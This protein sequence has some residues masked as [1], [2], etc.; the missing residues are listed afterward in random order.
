MSKSDIIAKNTLFLYIRMGLVLIVSLYTV[1]VLLVALGIVEYGV[2]SAVGGVINTLSF[3]SAVLTNASQ[4]FFSIEIGKDNQNQLKEIFNS[5]FILYVLAG[6]ILL[7][8]FETIGLWFLHNKMTIPEESKIAA[9]WVFQCV[10]ISFIV[11]FMSSPFQSLIIA[12]ERMNI[13]AVVGLIDVFLKLSITVIILYIKDYRLIIYSLLL[14]LETL[15]CQIIYILYCSRHYNIKDIHLSLNKTIIYPIINYTKWSIVGAIAFISNTQG[16]NVI[17]NVFFGPVINTAYA[18]GNQVKNAINLFGSNFF[19]AV[20]PAMIKEYTADNIKY[21]RQLFY[22]SSKMIF[23]LLYIFSLPLLLETLTI[24]NLWLTDINTDMIVF[25]RLMLIASIILS[26]S[27][28]ITTTIQASGDVKKYHLY[29]DGFILVTLPLIYTAFILG[30]PAQYAIIISIIVL[31]FAHL[32]RL[33]L[34][35]QIIE[36]RIWDYFIKIILPIGLTIFISFSICYLLSN[37]IPF[38]TLTSILKCL[39][40]AIIALL[41][42]VFVMLSTNEKKRLFDIIKSILR[43]KN[44][45]LKEYS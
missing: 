14:L 34:V 17:L 18:I 21:F 41:T 28:P 3:V 7:V 11:T 15:V 10:T 45:N 32:I 20:R 24:M 4:R 16:I 6:V 27:E 37:I 1:R 36:L 29:V 44:K 42:S 39:L 8:L 26:L 19:L 33:I 9:N 12:H 43:L 25:V 31:S 30:L 13:Y 23:I 40:D 5:I 22:F 38:N 2:Y 35:N